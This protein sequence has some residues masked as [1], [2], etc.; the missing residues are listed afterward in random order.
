MTTRSIL[1][2]GSRDNSP[3]SSDSR[4]WHQQKL[5]R[6]AAIDWQGDLYL[7]AARLDF[8]WS[9]EFRSARYHSNSPFYPNFKRMTLI[10]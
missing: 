2:A 5:R 7:L 6:A 9:F 8:D 4:Y 3:R 1:D 10:R